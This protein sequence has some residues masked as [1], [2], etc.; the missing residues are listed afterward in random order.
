MWKDGEVALTLIG[1]LSPQFR[2][3]HCL[4]ILCPQLTFCLVS[5]LME[6]AFQHI[7]RTVWLPFTLIVFFFHW[8]FSTRAHNGRV[9]STFPPF[10]GVCILSW[11][12][13]LLQT[14]KMIYLCIFNKLFRKAHNLLWCLQSHFTNSTSGNCNFSLDIF[15][16]EN[17]FCF[18]RSF[19]LF[20]WACPT[21]LP[22]LNT[23][24][25]T[26]P[27]TL[28]TYFCELECYTTSTL[29]SSSVA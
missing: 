28:W 11:I 27:N 24:L 13:A 29:Q 1:V 4:S 7:L 8:T 12:I 6:G 25:G 14:T 18:T 21:W 3:N 10:P 23:F 2:M 5:Q 20:P 16:A 19:M 26:S 17:C 22:H 15:R 9:E